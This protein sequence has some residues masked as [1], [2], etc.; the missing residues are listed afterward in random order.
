M[1]GYLI[2]YTGRLCL[3]GGEKE[4]GFVLSGA[5]RK[6]KNASFFWGRNVFLAVAPR[7]RDWV[8]LPVG[9]GL[10]KEKG[11]TGGAI[12]K[13]GSIRFSS[14]PRQTRWKSFFL[15]EGLQR[16][17]F[18]QRGKGKRHAIPLASESKRKSKESPLVLSFGD[19]E[20]K[21]FAF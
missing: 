13:L 10:A 21:R 8:Y 2:P 18:G 4:S 11:D 15:K 17:A 5:G 12:K 3:W 1:F 20:K 7:V 6:P 19:C 16:I 9:S 14:A